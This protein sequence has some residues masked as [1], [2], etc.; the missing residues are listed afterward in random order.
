MSYARCLAL[1]KNY[2]PYKE[3][4]KKYSEEEKQSE[5]VRYGADVRAFREFKIID[6]YSMLKALMRMV[7][8]IEYQ[9]GISAVRRNYGKK[10]K[11]NATDETHSNNHRKTKQNSM[12]IERNFQRWKLS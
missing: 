10:K 4:R 1:N 6:Q 7:S 9:V 3:A 5:P 8:N 2:K 11:W 12:P